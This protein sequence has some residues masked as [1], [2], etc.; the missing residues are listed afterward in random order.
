MKMSDG[1]EWGLHCLTLIATA[2]AGTILPGK[3]LAE[4]H[5]VSESYMLK[6]LKTLAKAGLLQSLPGARGGFRLG[7]P[8]EAITALDVVD[9]IEGR[10]PAFRCAEIR[11]CGPAAALPSAYRSPCGIHRAM[12]AAEQAWRQALRDIRLSDL[13][14]NLGDS[15]PS[16][17]IPKAQAWLQAAAR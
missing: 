9:A 4:F 6:H 11:Q 8:A 7:R 15:A 5:G 2:P 1:V 14:A 10:G 17:S 16:E 12:A 3:A 13:V